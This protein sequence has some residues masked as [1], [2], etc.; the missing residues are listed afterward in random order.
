MFNSFIAWNMWEEGGGQM[1]GV[2]T[3]MGAFVQGANVLP[4][5]DKYTEP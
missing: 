3:E 2:V 1:S 5:A 4:S